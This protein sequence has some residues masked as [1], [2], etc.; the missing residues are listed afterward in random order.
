MSMPLALSFMSFLRSLLGGGAGADLVVEAIAT[1]LVLGSR[2][3]LPLADAARRLLDGLARDRQVVEGRRVPPG[4]T[5]LEEAQL[6]PRGQPPGHLVLSERL[7][8]ELEALLRALVRLL[9]VGHVARLVVDDHETLGGLV[10]PVEAPANPVEAEVESEL[11]L[12]VG[13]LLPGGLLLVIEAGERRHPRPLALLLVVAGEETLVPP[14]VVEGEQE[15]LERG[16]VAGRAATQVELHR[17][18][19]RAAVDHRVV[20]PQRDAQD[21]DVLVLR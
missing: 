8:L 12:H 6:H 17:V 18:V 9:L 5:G 7:D 10:D 1:G 3:E 19:E 11:P 13:G 4:E 2:L 14:R 21:V 15:S 16:V 20:L